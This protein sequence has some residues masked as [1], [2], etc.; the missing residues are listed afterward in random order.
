MMK[1]AI[2]MVAL[3]VPAAG[4]HYLPGM[5]LRDYAAGEPVGPIKVNS[6]FSHDGIVTYDF[7]SLKFCTPPK[8]ELNEFQKEEKLGEIIWGD[9][10][11]NSLYRAEMMKD[12]QCRVVECGE[13][14]NKVSPTDLQRFT[15]RINN[16]YRGTFVLDNLV[17]VSN[18]SWVMNGHCPTGEQIYDYALRGYMLGVPKKCVGKRT[19]INNHLALHIHANEHVPGR[20]II[21]QF[22]VVPYSINHPD[23]EA[24]SDSFK[25]GG[26]DPPV[27]TDPAETKEIIWSYS[28][29]WHASS[30]GWANRWDSYLSLAFSN[31]S[32]RVHW[33]S[34]INSLLIIL[35]L[36]AIVAMILLRTLHMDFNRYNSP[37]D[38]DEAQE[39]VGWKLVHADVFRAPEREGL[40]SIFIGTGVQLHGMFGLSLVFAL[41]GFL[42]P[43]NRGGLITATILFYVLMSVLNG[44]VVGM[45]L[46]MFHARQ[47]KTVFAAGLLYP[48]IMFTLWMVAEGVIWVTSHKKG[49]N[50]APIVSVLAIMGLWFC[51][52]L[53]FVVLGASFGFRGPLIEPPVKIQK[54]ERP[55]PPQ[56]WYLQDACLF[57]IPGVI[58]FGAAFIELRFILSSIWQGMVYYVFGFLAL[59]Y[60]TVVITVAEVTIVLVYFMLVFENHK[61][62][63]RS[64]VAPGSMAIH[65]FFYSTYYFFSQ[66]QV[67]T[68]LATFI[69]FQTMG[70]ISFSIYIAAGTIG[71][72]S[73]FL[74]TYIIYSSIK[75]E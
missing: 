1:W 75:V 19:H 48:G 10:I 62:W 11:E 39:E 57:I 51:I 60:V 17:V 44:F 29:K 15:R 66:L 72:V 27:T 55:I 46:K 53:P 47:W 38:A 36:S 18:G 21:T 4:Y 34:I 56:R 9:R 20:Y 70:L 43:A 74:F 16:G 14:Q 7:Y 31:S 40:F 49:A 50:T 37:E 6:L 63:W 61:W 73:S 32:A 25:T 8:N 2:G 64:V 33:L 69:Y 23:K 42:S 30:V 3:A 35:C 12:V 58:P 45:M 65:F 67:R 22:N 71:A 13:G 41:V 52:S 26:N 54:I 68:W 28:V 24:C 59:T 5:E